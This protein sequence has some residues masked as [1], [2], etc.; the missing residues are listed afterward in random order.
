[1]ST[2]RVISDEELLQLPKDGNKYELVDGELRV[3][4]AGD[5]LPGSSCPL[6]DILR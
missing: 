3:S 6:A 1:M 5:V 4:P 2:I